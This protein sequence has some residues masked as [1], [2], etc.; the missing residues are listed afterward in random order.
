V[1]LKLKQSLLVSAMVAAGSLQAGGLTSQII[2]N[3]FYRA[4]DLAGGNEFAELVLMQDL[5]AAELN[6]FFVG[7][8]TGSTAA[9]FSGYQFTNMENFAN[10]FCAGTIITVAGDTGPAADTTYDPGT[11]DWN[12]T[13]N[14][15]G[16]NLTTNGSTGNF[17]G[18]DVVYVDTDG[19]NGN[20]TIATEGF[21][22]NWDSSPGVFGGNAT[23]TLTNAPAN[24]TGAFLA[25]QVQLADQDAQW[26][27]DTALGSLTPGQGNGGF[28][29]AT[30]DDLRNAYGNVTLTGSPS[31]NE[32][33]AGTTAFDFTV[34]RSNTCLPATLAYVV[35]GSGANPADA[36]DFGGAFPAGNINF[37]AGQAQVTLTINVSGDTDVEMDEGFLVEIPLPVPPRG[38][39]LAQD[40]GTI[41]NDDALVV[42]NITIDD[43]TQ[44]EGNAGSSTFDFTVSL[45]ASADVSVQVDT[46]DGTA[47][48][49]D[50]DYNSIVGQVIN[51]TSGGATSQTVSVTVNGD[52]TVEGDETFTVNLSNAT[53]G[54]ITDGTGDGIISNDDAAN[55]SIDDVTLSE[56]D[57]GTTAYDFTV[58]IDQSVNASVQV[59][60]ADGTATTADNDYQA[61]VGQV[62]NFTAGGATTQ[63]VTVLVNGDVT[64]EGNETFNVNLSNVSGAQIADNQGVGTINNDDSVQ[65]QLVLT[66]SVAGGIRPGEVATYTILVENIGPND[67]FD[68][69]GDEVTDVLPPEVTFLSAGAS[70]GAV[71]NVGNTV[72]W[73]G[74]VVAGGSVTIT[75]DVTINVGVRGDVANQAQGFFDSNGDNNNDSSVLSNPPNA[76]GPTIFGVI[77]D[78]PVPGLGFI[79]LLLLAGLMMLVPRIRRR[80]S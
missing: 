80:L 61:V 24:N 50:N 49:A 1:L 74:V 66:K 73:N 33:D 62:V 67:Q 56:G 20:T 47:T 21:A 46:A 4:G 15:S 70:S 45:D 10:T 28:N 51:F 71:S 77:N 11:N 52:T 39:N 35:S 53:G 60:T 14:T 27:S 72:S 8:S 59:D 29:S 26:T 57:A 17:A 41:L 63:T 48:T 3:E 42:P 64:I 7:D 25:G 76:V 44:A 19:T 2:V 18:T 69:A 32:G 40:N 58:S 54:V 12:L 37:A 23:F 78:I 13:L 79:G 75:I 5:T 68:N 30:I 16:A 55:I 34:T 38:G 65:A 31:L 43:V 22:I 9:K 36:A 6:A